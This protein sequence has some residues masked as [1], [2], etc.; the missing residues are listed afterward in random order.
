M[1][2]ALPRSEPREAFRT[3]KDPYSVAPEQLQSLLSLSTTSLSRFLPR[4]I[5]EERVLRERVAELDRA[6]L[7]NVGNLD[8]AMRQ[9]IEEA[10]RRF[11]FSLR[12]ELAQAVSA[13]S[14]AMRIALDRHRDQEKAVSHFVLEAT[15]SIGRLDYVLQG[16]ATAT[17]VKPA[18]THPECEAVMLRLSRAKVIDE[19]EYIIDRPIMAVLAHFVGKNAASSVA[20]N[21]TAFA[22]SSTASTST[23]PAYDRLAPLRHRWEALIVSQ[24]WRN[25]AN[26]E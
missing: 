17:A 2:I 11:E 3:D 20:R 25:A 7:R 8:W 9:N 13:T 21:V 19:I 14:A 5:R 16:L 22:D 15:A 24:F 1:D 12:D 4:K 23:S 6:V 18:Q 26:E 10:F